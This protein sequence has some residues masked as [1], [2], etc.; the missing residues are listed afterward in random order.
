VDEGVSNLSV[1]TEEVRA[2]SRVHAHILTTVPLSHR[3][4]AALAR[5][6]TLV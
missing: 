3:T 5:S 1:R 4:L 6:P 2:G